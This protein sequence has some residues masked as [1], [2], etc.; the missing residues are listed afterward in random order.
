MHQVVFWSRRLAFGLHALM[1]ASIDQVRPWKA[2]LS[3][4]QAFGPKSAAHSQLADN[5]SNR[6][7]FA[8]PLMGREVHAV[9][10][11]AEAGS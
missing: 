11:S 4:T 8:D 6:V 3:H 5:C 1:A 9:L 2:Y 10:D 7:D